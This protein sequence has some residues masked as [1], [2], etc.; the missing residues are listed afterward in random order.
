MESL[1][2]VWKD[3]KKISNWTINGDSIAG[4]RT[5]YYIN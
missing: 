4:I 1:Y 5:S 2:S 3:N